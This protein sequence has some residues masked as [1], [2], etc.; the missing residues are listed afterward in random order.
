M[1]ALEKL[2]EVT[3]S[4][5]TPTTNPAADKAAWELAGRL[6]SR[7]PTDQPAVTTTIKA[8]DHAALDALVTALEQPAAPPPPKAP[9]V[10]VS[11]EEMNNAMRAFRKRLKLTRLED[12]S[13][14]GARQMTAGRQSAIRGIIPPREFTKAVWDAL[15]ADGKLRYTGQG[16]YSPTDEP[17]VG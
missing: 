17:A 7:M 5:Q 14:L 6:L 13:R 11:Q 2:R 4:L 3:N 16:F 9:A 8:R 15:V 10:E 12:E 1:N